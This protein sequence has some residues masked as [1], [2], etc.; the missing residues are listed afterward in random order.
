MVQNQ[1]S[2]SQRIHSQLQETIPNDS[3]YD[4]HTTI[5]N[6]IQASINQVLDAQTFDV[7][8][9]ISIDNAPSSNNKSNT[10]IRTSTSTIQCQVDNNVNINTNRRSPRILQLNETRE[11]STEVLREATTEF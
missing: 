1:S 10:S 5:D 2:M 11:S 6:Q 4:K 7:E 9:R 3:S 8:P